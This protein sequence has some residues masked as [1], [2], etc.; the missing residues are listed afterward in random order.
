[1]QINLIKRSISEISG[2]RGRLNHP[3]IAYG[4]WAADNF[5]NRPSIIVISHSYFISWFIR[6]HSYEID[7]ITTTLQRTNTYLTH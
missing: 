2:I 3:L 5:I 4:P 1:M 6:R 7:V